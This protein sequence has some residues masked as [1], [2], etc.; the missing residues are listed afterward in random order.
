MLELFG[1]LSILARFCEE[2]SQAI[3]QKGSAS[4]IQTINVKISDVKLMK[5]AAVS[6]F[7]S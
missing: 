2:A 6:F 4:L 5:K 1:I 7:S 3:C